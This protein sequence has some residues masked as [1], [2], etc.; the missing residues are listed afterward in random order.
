MAYRHPERHQMMILP[1]SIDEYIGDEDPVRAYDA[2]IDTMGMEALGMNWE[3]DKVGCPQYN[4]MVMLKILVYGYSYGIRSSRKLERALH[5]NLSFIWIAG[6]LKPDHKTI[7]RFR[8]DNQD[9]LKGVL[10]QCARICIEMGLIDG[11]TLF[12][13]GSKFRGNASLNNQWD[14]E[15]CKRFMKRIDSRIDEI[16]NECEVEDVAESGD[17]SLVKLKEEL[18]SQENL[19]S[20]VEGILEKIQTEELQHYNSTDPDTGRMH[21]VH[22]SFAG[23]NAQIVV[24]DKHGLIVSSDA[25][26]ANNDVGQFASQIEQ[27]NEV[28][29]K[30]CEN[31]C[32]DAGYS[33]ANELEKVDAQGIEVIVP[34][35]RQA[36][37][38]EP[39]NFDKTRFLY[40]AEED[41]YICPEG[42]KLP[43]RR[44]VKNRGLTEYYGGRQACRNCRHFG[45]CTK[46]KTTGR[47]I[48]RYKNEEI[49]E[50]LAA[51]YEK[52]SSQA[53]FARRKEKAELPFGHIKRNL[54][55]D[56]FLMRGL[57]GVRAEIS[58][59]TSC[60]DIARLIGIFG[61]SRL[62]KVL[63]ELR[64]EPPGSS[65]SITQKPVKT[66]G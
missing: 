60:F 3:P 11:N 35:S 43:A 27:A 36:S 34:S 10:R 41:C 8:R 16:M 38:K 50:K 6:G 51:Q 24:D 58:I 5:H 7:S 22:G 31:A 19:K 1:P 52:P 61:V 42:V 37:G 48:I 47:K 15:R 39:G 59:L 30:P 28:L 14:E 21:G 2:M 12:V 65:A 18:Q 64:G 46:N 53:V 44:F 62:L 17:G 9:V 57:S 40:N 49:R 55:A 54:G 33:N 4:P 20:K 45:V 32:A 29:G 63:S 13:D 56:N 23:Y 66:A 25:V 26:S